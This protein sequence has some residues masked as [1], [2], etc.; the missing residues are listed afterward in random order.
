MDRAAT[1]DFW[2]VRTPKWPLHRRADAV[3]YFSKYSQGLDQALAALPPMAALMD[4]N[5]PERQIQHEDMDHFKKLEILALISFSR[6]KQSF[7]K[8]L[9]KLQIRPASLF[10]NKFIMNIRVTFSF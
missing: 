9:A 1:V 5:S 4:I 10:V 8:S 2:Q 3:F 7:D 6:G